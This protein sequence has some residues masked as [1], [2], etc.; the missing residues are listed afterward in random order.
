MTPH[1][2]LR[3][4]RVS[5]KRE[6]ARDIHAIT[7]ADPDGSPLPAFTAGAHLP[8]Q[9]PSGAMRHYSLCGDPRDT[10]AYQ[11]AVKRESSGRGGSVS[12]IDGVQEGD[13]LQVGMPDNQFAL[14]DKARSFIL[15]AGGIG[16]TPMMAMV[17][18]LQAEGQRPF[19]LYYL[20]RDPASTSFLEDLQAPEL[21]GQVLIHHDDGDP[22]RSLDLW[23]ILEKAASGVHVYCC[24]PKGLM[25]SVQDMSGHWPGSAVHFESFGADTQVRADDQAF[26]VVLQASGQ[27]IMV[28]AG[29]SILEALRAQGLRVPSSCE[30]GTCGSCKVGVVQGQV[31]HRD[32]VLLPEER[33][34]HVMVC[35]SRAQGS[36]PLVLDL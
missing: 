24:G 4:L 23:P 28:P 1:L 7:L 33:D 16:V 12:L 27:R 29:Q 30:S 21:A 2:A 3:P 13:T 31:D 5:R 10:S 36:G 8:V 19:K 32:L 6:I 25:D 17:R 11:L 9:V 20:A 34:H 14:S 18:Q 22:A 26:E 15:I 35:V